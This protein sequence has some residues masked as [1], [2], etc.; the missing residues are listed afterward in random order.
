MHRWI[1]QGMPKKQVVRFGK[2]LFDTEEVIGWL[3][4]QGQNIN[5]KIE[6]VRR[7]SNAI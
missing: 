5:A 2:L 4:N 7:L 3:T 1:N 6:K